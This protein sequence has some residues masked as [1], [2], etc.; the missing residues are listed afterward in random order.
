MRD[1]VCTRNPTWL[2][3]CAR[4]R[5]RGRVRARLAAAQSGPRGYLSNKTALAVIFKL[6]QA[7]EKSWHR[8]R[9]HEQLPKVI[10]GV[11]FNNK[12]EVANRELKPLSCLTSLVTKTWRR[13][14]AHNLYLKTFF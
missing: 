5:C 9:G 10:L 1:C 14:A 4:S 7:A 8:L 6:A 3:T 11:K 2:V 13:L 12:I